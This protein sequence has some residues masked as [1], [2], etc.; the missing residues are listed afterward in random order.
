VDRLDNAAT[1]FGM[2]ISGEKTKIM[3]NNTHGFNATIKL[4]ETR[5]ENVAK[6][7]YLGSIISDEGS[8]P[9]ILARSAQTVAALARLNTIWKDKNICLRSKINLMRALT[10]SI[11][12]YGC[13]TWT[14]TTELQKRILSMEMRCYRKILGITYLDRVTNEEIRNKV[15]QAI[16]PHD[17]LLTTV[18]KRKLRWFG[19]AA[20]SSGLTKT[21]L[22]GTVPG[23][24]KRGRQKK[25]WEDNIKEWTGL[26]L[27][28]AIRAAEDRDRWRRIVDEVMVPQR[29]TQ[30]SRDR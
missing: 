2:E 7:K 30:R 6:F 22:Q 23:S 26:N 12:L 17:N 16:G 9:E 24:R 19:H 4:G 21:I 1:A 14:L 10:L 20:R 3:T 5:L 25:R 28:E 8:R 13:E 29:P 18:K 11:Y 15:V 27:A